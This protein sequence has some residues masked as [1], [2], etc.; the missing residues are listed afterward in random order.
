MAR[1]RR[2]PTRVE[3]LAEALK[4]AQESAAL[5]LAIDLRTCTRE[6]R[7]SVKEGRNAAKQLVG[8]LEDA[9]ALDE[10]IAP[11]TRVATSTG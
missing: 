5:L 2:P 4:A 1:T 9:L 8:S 3:Q 11:R 10:P 6:I 7:D